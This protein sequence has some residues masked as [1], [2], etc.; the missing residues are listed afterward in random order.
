MFQKTKA[1]IKKRVNILA[2]RLIK[3]YAERN[4]IPGFSCK[5]DDEFQIAFEKAFPYVLTEDQEKAI[6]EIKKD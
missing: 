2:E 6:A 5:E 1:K 4:S 3:L